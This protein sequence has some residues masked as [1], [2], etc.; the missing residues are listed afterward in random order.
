MRWNRSHDQYYF[1]QPNQIVSEPP[2]VPV[3]YVENGVIAHRHV[4]SLVLGR[5]FSEWLE[6]GDRA[7]LFAAW[8]NA[9]HF[10]KHDGDIALTDYV[11][12][13]W[14]ALIEQCTSIV[15]LKPA[16]T[17]RRMVD[18]TCRRRAVDRRRMRPDRR[19]PLGA[20][21][22][23][24]TSE[25]RI[26]QSMSSS[27]L[28]RTMTMKTTLMNHKTFTPGSRVTYKSR[29]RSTLPA[30]RSSSA[31]SRKHTSI[32]VPQFMIRRARVP[33]YRPRE[34]LSECRQCK[35]V[36]LTANEEQPPSSCPEVRWLKH[37]HRSLPPTTRL[38]RRRRP[39][40]WW[41][42][43]VHER[44]TRAGR[45]YA[46]GAAA[47]GSERARPRHEPCRLCPEALLIGPRG[48]SLHAKHGSRL[49]GPWLR[50]LSNLWTTPRSRSTR[51]PHLPD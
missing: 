10:L 38:Q 20:H 4:R 11:E 35:A 32:A 46:A 1:H 31:D 17:R 18:G 16:C 39:A 2:R 33:D 48:R 13:Q 43:E 51:P 30:P 47:G 9:G 15:G 23:R 24:V 41:K 5:F 29:F 50:P 7:N 45:I 26:F 40:R 34:R 12:R 19:P 27:C 36:T 37:A 14:G 3:L 25:V 44:W 21:A 6:D 8:G 49:V 42:T 28:S 22:P